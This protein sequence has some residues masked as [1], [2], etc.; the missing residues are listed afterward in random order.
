LK[1]WRGNEELTRQDLRGKLAVDASAL[2]ELIFCE[3]PG[4]KLKQ[5][6]EREQ[7]EA[8]TTELAI[9][10]LRYILCRKL[11]WDESSRRVN[12]LLE[13]GYFKIVNTSELVEVAA[14]L[15]C[16]RAI[17]LPDCFTIVLAEKIGGGV[18]FARTEQDLTGEMHREPFK[19]AVFFLENG[20]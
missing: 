14:K 16:C 5:A 11:G 1:I 19:V 9:T 6:L 2:I 10:E 13:S 17:S 3:A 18:L 4:Q 12:K 8:W 15:K 7:I 20:D